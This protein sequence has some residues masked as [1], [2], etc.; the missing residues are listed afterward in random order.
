MPIIWCMVIIILFKIKNVYIYFK[1][2]LMSLLL[3]SLP[4][5]IESLMYPLTNGSSKFI[6]GDDISAVIVL[7]AGSY[8]D[9]NEKWYPSGTSVK[10]VVLANN[11]A[12]ITNVPLIIL[13]GNKTENLPSESLLVSKYINNN[14]FL[15][16]TKSKN[17]YQSVKNL[18]K[19][20]LKINLNKNNNY[21]VVTSDIHN[22]RTALTFKSQGYKIKILNYN[23]LNKISFADFIPNSKSFILLN[24]CLYEYFGIIKYVFLGYIKVN[25]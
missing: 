10:R 21:L 11:I 16:D 23:S 5:V 1:I 3:L 17:T 19:K 25:I 20:L 2:I 12:K 4:I 22:L 18:E 15:L 8:K 24:N 14:N 7:T 9:V 13:G 6:T